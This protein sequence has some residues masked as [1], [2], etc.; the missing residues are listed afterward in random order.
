MHIGSIGVFLLGA[1]SIDECGGYIKQ[2]NHYL[3]HGNEH[4][5]HLLLANMLSKRDTHAGLK[6]SHYI[7]KF[8]ICGWYL[9]SITVSLHYLFSKSDV[10]LR[11]RNEYANHILH[12][13]L[14]GRREIQH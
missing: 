10:T 2:S 8:S 5:N 13:L 4:S 1:Y 14:S 7:T 3:Q 9:C 12:S 11:T 6:L